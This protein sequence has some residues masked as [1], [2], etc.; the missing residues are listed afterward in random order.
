MI[1]T[2]AATLEF[3]LPELK[4]HCLHMLTTGITADTACTTLIAARL[5]LGTIADES[6]VVREVE[7][8]CVDYIQ[9]NT[10]TVF[11]SKGFLQLPK[12]TLLSI[13]QSSKVRTSNTKSKFT[14]AQ[15]EP[16]IWTPLKMF[17]RCPD[18]K[19]LCI[20]FPASIQDATAFTLNLA[21]V[22]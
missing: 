14:V 18:L 13:I 5:N 17:L 6:N 22:E 2:I 10:R 19:C 3:G 16:K 7:E 8:A 1:K 12:E 9:S 11:K 4:T 15:K 21:T 20:K